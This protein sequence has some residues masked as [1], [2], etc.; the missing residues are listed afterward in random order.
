MKIIREINRDVW[1]QFVKQN[2]GISGPEFLLS[3]D[4]FDIINREEPG[5]LALAVVKD[6][7]YKGKELQIDDILALIILVKKPL[8]YG[9]FYWYAPRGPLLNI[10]LEKDK[11]IE[12]VKFLFLSIW[13][14][15]KSALFLKI[16]PALRGKEFWQTVF[17]A[18]SFRFFQVKKVKDIQPKK[19]VVLNLKDNLDD[20]LKRMHQKTRYNI[21]LAKKKGVVIK[22]GNSQDFVEFWR[23]M[24]LTGERDGFRIHKEEHYKNLLSSSSE[25]IKLFF[26]EYEDKKIATALI[27]FFGKKATYLHGASDN[28][29][30]QV[31]AP[32]LLQWE[33]IKRAKE[34]NC[35]LYDFYGIDEKKWPGV[36]RFKRGFGGDEKKYAGA[37]DIVFRPSMYR[38]YR[39][40]KFVLNFISRIRK[41]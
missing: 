2:Q 27:C 7:D 23:L 3:P 38:V 20:I 28:N 14:L 25:F 22:E 33:I 1:A 40:L 30:R 11:Q 32:H 4:W 41:S 29:F 21:R 26:V 6:L 13:H 35:W 36:T 5:S 8:K 31:M 19:T 16:E 17:F 39:M 9:F 18:S 10:V 12:V 34:E 15:N 37:F 24:Q